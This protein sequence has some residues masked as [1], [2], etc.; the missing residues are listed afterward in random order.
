MNI[1]VEGVKENL[2][3]IQ[4]HYTVELTNAPQLVNGS[5]GLVYWASLITDVGRSL[6]NDVIILSLG[7]Q[8]INGYEKMDA[9]VYYCDTDSVILNEIAYNNL[10]KSERV[11]IDNVI[12]GGLKDEYPDSILK[13]IRI[14]NK[15]V[16]QYKINGQWINKFKGVKNPEDSFYERLKNTGSFKT[17][18]T[19]FSKK[20][21]AVS[22]VKN[23]DM[24]ICQ[25]LAR[26]I[27]SEDRRIK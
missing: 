27:K 15:K 18:Q 24:L 1:K 4:N 3:G 14:L 19:K 2:F 25:R 26:K 6:I 5:G 20:L 12:L 13:E 23:L 8:K 10:L 21:G 11:L 22:I 7:Q 17:K 16:Y 9:R